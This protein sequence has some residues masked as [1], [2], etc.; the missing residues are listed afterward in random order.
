MNAYIRHDLANKLNNQQ[1]VF[2][3]CPGWYHKDEQENN[4]FNNK[5]GIETVNYL[6]FDINF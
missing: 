1:M 5:K 6:L 2:C 4:L 3:I